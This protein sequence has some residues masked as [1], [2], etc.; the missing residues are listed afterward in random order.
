MGQR[1]GKRHARQNEEEGPAGISGIGCEKGFLIRFEEKRLTW[2]EN[3]KIVIV[4]VI[5]M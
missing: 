1:L 2:R 3:N 4:I 5:V